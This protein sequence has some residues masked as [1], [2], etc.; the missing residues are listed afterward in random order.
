MASRSCEVFVADVDDEKLMAYLEKFF[1]LILMHYY[2]VARVMVFRL[3]V[4]KELCW[5]RPQNF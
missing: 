4:A 1:M 2:P 5:T 3:T